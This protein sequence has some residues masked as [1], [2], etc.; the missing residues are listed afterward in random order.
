MNSFKI[1]FIFSF[2]FLAFSCLAFGEGKEIKEI[3]ATNASE[4]IYTQ[5]E[6]DESLNKKLLEEVQKIKKTGLV[7]LT[8]SILNREQALLEK[9]EQLKQKEMEFSYQVKDFETRISSFEKQQKEFLACNQRV[10]KDAGVR[11]TK[12]VDVISTMKPDKAAA[13]LATQEPELAVKILSQLESQKTSKIFNL[14]DKE[15]SAQLQ[16]MYLDMKR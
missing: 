1:K 11:V 6:F 4:K 16:K 13:L 3:K 10:E 7:E 14:M 15:K 5:K 2:L 12:M 9:E 8:Q